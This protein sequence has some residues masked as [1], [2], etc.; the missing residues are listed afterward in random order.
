ME[1]YETR[2]NQKVAA[3]KTQLTKSRVIPFDG[4]LS[5]SMERVAAV[6]AECNKLHLD[7]EELMAC[8]M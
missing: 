7:F 3:E 2:V 6:T 4:K 5:S 8:N 1:V